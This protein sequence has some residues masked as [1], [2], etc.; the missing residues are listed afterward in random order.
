MQLNNAKKHEQ[1]LKIFFYN[2]SP[3]QKKNFASQKRKRILESFFI[4]AIQPQIMKKN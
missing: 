2:T 1:G 3:K 4:V